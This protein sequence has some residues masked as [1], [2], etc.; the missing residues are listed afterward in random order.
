MSGHQLFLVILNL[1]L[2]NL[3]ILSFTEHL[4]LWIFNAGGLWSPIFFGHVKFEVKNF[5]E[6]FNLQSATES[7]FFAGCIWAPTF[8]GHAKYEIKNFLEYFHLQ[9]ALNWIFIDGGLGQLIL[10]KLNLRLKI[11]R[12]FLIYRLLWTL[13][14][15][16]GVSGY[17]IF[18]VT[19]ILRSK[20]FRNFFVYRVLST[21]NF[22]LGSEVS[23]HQLYW[24]MLNLRSKIFWNFFAYIGLWILNFSEWVSGH[25]LF[26]SH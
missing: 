15:L 3:G 21:L 10:V 2:K 26:W 18:L 6:F 25:Q 12:N 24:V 23:G 22:P 19:L 7:E 9:S 16:Q 17:Q 11:F 1:R 14:F 5:L 8:F 20:I 4:G 13:I